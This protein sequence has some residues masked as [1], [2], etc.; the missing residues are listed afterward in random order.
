[1]YPGERFNSI[2]HLVGS[3]LA[4]AGAAVLIVSAALGGDPWRI[5]GVSI[6]GAML[7][8]LYTVSALYH[9]IRSERAKAVLRKLDHAAIFLLIAGTYT[10][11]ALVTLRGALGWTLLA[12]I[13]LM[14]AWGIWRALR[15][16]NVRDPSPWPYLIMGWLGVSAAVPLVQ[17]L[18]PHGVFWLVAG[19]ALYS[20]GV[21]FYMNDT[22]WR[23]AHGVWHLFVLGGSAA[24]FVTV[25]FFVR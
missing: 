16:T 18:G 9:S 7:V 6:F 25:L 11:F 5:V 17:S 15:Q 19:G 22:R 8:T 13:W 2:S 10:P 1:M 23:H 14:A 12:T 3:A 4:V 20:A 24:H 21:V